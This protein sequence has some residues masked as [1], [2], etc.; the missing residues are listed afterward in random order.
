MITMLLVVLMLG[1]LSPAVA[2]PSAQGTEAQVEPNAG[3]WTTWVLESGSQFRLDAPPDEAATTDEI[4]QLMEM[5]G[6]RDEAG[7]QQIAYWN[8]GPPSY[9]WN[10][11]GA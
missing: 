8:A 2:S 3:S 9:R 1:T 4:A 6:D 5:A 10:E 7:L 11:I